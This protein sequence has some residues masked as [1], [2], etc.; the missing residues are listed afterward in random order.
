MAHILFLNTLGL[1]SDPENPVSY[2]VWVFNPH[3]KEISILEMCQLNAQNGI[4]TGARRELRD[5]HFLDKET[6]ACL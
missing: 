2:I 3:I 1:V 5:H 6:K 4:T